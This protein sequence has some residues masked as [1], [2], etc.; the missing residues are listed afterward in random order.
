MEVS[1][2]CSRIPAARRLTN[3]NVTDDSAADGPDPPAGGTDLRTSA[4]E[5]FRTYY[6]ELVRLAKMWVGSLE[7]AEDVVQEVFAS[8]TTASI[9]NPGAYLRAATANRAR[10][11][12]RRRNL[13]QRHRVAAGALGEPAEQVHHSDD[14]LVAA[15]RRL[16]A[17]QRD[18]LILRYYLDW[19]AR[20]TAEFLGIDESAVRSSTY[21][22]LQTLRT[23]FTRGS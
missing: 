9:A 11:V 17:R 18:V 23:E 13:E 15:I 22:A 10:S 5:M 14:Q 12:V 21:R 19:T 20:T 1:S 6:L 2:G 8:V 7:A 16:P 3:V 4:E